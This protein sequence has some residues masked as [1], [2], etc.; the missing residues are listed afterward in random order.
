MDK[1]LTK[2]QSRCQ[3]AKPLTTAR[4]YR[5]AAKQKPLARRTFLR[6]LGITMG[7]PWLETMETIAS[8]AHA[9]E[10]KATPPVR[11]AFI[12][13]PNGAIMP[14][15]NP[16]ESDSDWELSPTLQPLACHKDQLTIIQG[17]MQH[18]GRANGDGAGDH[19]RCA[20][21]FLTG[22]QPYKTAGSDIQLG[23]SVDQAAAELIG[24]QTRLASLELGIER[25]RQGGNCDSG[26]SCAYSSNI[27]WKTN[28]Q[29]QTKEI[30]PRL[31]FE[32]LFGST[33]LA[34]RAKQNHHRTSILDLVG[35]DAT[36]LRKR[37]GRNDRRKLEE[38]FTGVRE[39]EQRISREATQLVGVPEVV[40]PEGCPS[41]TTNTHSLNVRCSNARFSNGLDSD[42]HFHAG[43]CGQQ[44]KLS[45]G[46]R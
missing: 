23:I 26:Y 44:S 45:D 27:S 33:N 16:E 14:S 38:Y 39:L 36:S 13:F 6:G 8:A 35:D 9:P 21:S 41:R 17:L 29:P 46:R 19:A 12:F 18:H 43:Q 25:G 42:C 1:I 37:L 4:W 22:Q 10:T 40:L 20:A 31:A 11:M 5:V 28:T 32:R 2:V 30:N 15:W 7:L 24:K 3:Q 34:D